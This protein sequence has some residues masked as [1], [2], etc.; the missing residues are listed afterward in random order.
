MVNKTRFR[1]RYYIFCDLKYNVFNW[2]SCSICIY[3]GG[4]RKDQISWLRETRPEIVVATPG[5]LDDLVCS[6]KSFLYYDV[7]KW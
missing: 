1:I 4:N 3:G 6:G 7:I 2:N 5:R